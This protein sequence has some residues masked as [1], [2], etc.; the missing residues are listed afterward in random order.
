MSK[1]IQYEVHR[2]G[3]GR[4]SVELLVKKVT[5]I[6]PGIQRGQVWWCDFPVMAAF[7]WETVK[8]RP[9]LIL[10]PAPQL[11]PS[12][13]LL[14]GRP[15]LASIAVMP[16]TSKI[17]EADFRFPI[18][19]VD[20]PGQLKLDAVL[21]V[22]RSR[23]IEQSPV[24]FPAT[25]FAK[26]QGRFRK[27]MGLGAEGGRQV[28]VIRRLAA[29]QAPLGEHDGR[30]AVVQRTASRAD[31]PTYVVPLRPL[32]GSLPASGAILTS[33]GQPALADLNMMLP[34]PASIL[35]ASVGTL[36]TTDIGRLR[37]KLVR[38]LGL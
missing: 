15:E 38:Q 1:E 37:A 20:R 26:L 22:P 21:T 13:R 24:D 28:G 14:P 23:L 27:F 35:G 7:P 5:E 2:S 12:Q 32:S 19:S 36:G 33:A 16:I 34:V 17:R 6:A 18:Q 9:V 4:G 31:A 29:D 8:K 11:R 30:V 10:S 3:P 25:E